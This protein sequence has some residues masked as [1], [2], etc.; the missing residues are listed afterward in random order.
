MPIVH[1]TT[2]KLADVVCSTAQGKIFD[3]AIFVSHK[4]LVMQNY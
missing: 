3:G 1:V 2:P 4:S